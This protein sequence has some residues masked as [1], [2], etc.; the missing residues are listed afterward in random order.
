MDNKTIETSVKN[1][2]RLMSPASQAQMKRVRE[3]VEEAMLDLTDSQIQCL[4][5]ILYYEKIL[6]EENKK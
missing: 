3:K 2:M 5:L 4:V 1:V 6:K